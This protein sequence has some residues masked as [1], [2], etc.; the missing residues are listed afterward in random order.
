MHVEGRDEG[1]K[2]ILWTHMKEP[3]SN[4][5]ALNQMVFLDD[6]GRLV[7]GHA[8]DY[9]IGALVERTPSSS[10]DVL[11]HQQ[12][13]MDDVETSSVFIHETTVFRNGEL[14][15]VDCDDLKPTDDD[16]DNLNKAHLKSDKDDN[17]DVQIS[18]KD[19]PNKED[20]SDNLK[21]DE[22]CVLDEE[23]LNDKLAEDAVIIDSENKMN[24]EA[25][26]VIETDTE[27]LGMSLVLVPIESDQVLHFE[28]RSPIP[29]EVVVDYWED[30]TDTRVRRSSIRSPSTGSQTKQ[31]NQSSSMS[32][33]WSGTKNLF[34]VCVLTL[35]LTTS[36]IFLNHVF[37]LLQSAAPSSSQLK[38]WMLGDAASS[39]EATR[40]PKPTPK[41]KTAPPV[42]PPVTPPVV[43][44]APLPPPIM[45][46]R[47]EEPSEI[48][49]E[50]MT[51]SLE[52]SLP[53]TAQGY[54]WKLLYN[55]VKHGYDFKS[56]IFSSSFL[57]N[58]T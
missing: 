40:N 12:H 31:S 39:E 6:K 36:Y 13:S 22:K 38:R 1:A 47:M 2:L 30:E 28:W 24:D 11:H 27:L 53:I 51:T 7:V 29:S 35:I 3:S 41:P 55:S 16:S 43:V 18:E 52:M 25:W 9:A 33:M 23:A 26:Q 20:S 54:K 37:C 14:I 17:K 42:T 58:Q 10:H 50:K 5:C 49:N 56:L 4:S 48:L 46:A 32:R 34:S 21:P 15:D 57:F 44:R 45:K 8:P 19:L